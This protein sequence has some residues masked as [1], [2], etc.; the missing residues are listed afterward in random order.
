MPCR[1]R[2][3]RPEVVRLGCDVTTVGHAMLRDEVAPGWTAT[4]DERHTEILIAD[5]LSRTVALGPGPHRIGF[6]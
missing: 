4:L 3:P 2:T 6:H 1:V 5:G